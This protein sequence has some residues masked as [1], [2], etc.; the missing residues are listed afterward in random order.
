M[1]DCPICGQT[2]AES[3]GQCPQ[4]GYSTGL[5]PPAPSSNRGQTI[6]RAYGEK[7]LQILVHPRLF[8]RSMPLKGGLSQPLVF[9]L[10]THWIGSALGFLWK[11]SLKGPTHYWAGAG[12]PLG[13]R[14]FSDDIDQMSRG[15][16]L[17]HYRDQILNWFWG[18]G[19]VIGD[20]ILTVFSILGT[21]FLV[22]IGARILVAPDPEV[23][24]AVT[25]ESAVKIIS[26][27]MTPHILK[28][29]PWVGP[30]FSSFGVMLLTIIGAQEVYRLSTLRAITIALFPKLLFIGIIL[31]GVFLIAFAFIHFVSL[32]F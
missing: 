20:P 5:A 18:A 28:A 9:A 15:T 4:C 17:L 13:F 30:Y 6:L 24:P 32:F 31:S 10:V 26:Y 8:F 25:Y 1:S 19:P 11:T 27:G 12:N 16:Y 3:A 22:F 14:F 23:R 2:L 29:L 21:S 7:L